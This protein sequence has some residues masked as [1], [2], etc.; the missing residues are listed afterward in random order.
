[1]ADPLVNARAAA[2]VKREQG[3]RAWSVYLHGTYAPFMTRAQV[4]VA[5]AR[6]HGRERITRVLQLA[7]AV[8]AWG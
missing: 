5:E 7:P 4:A 6:G 2:L 1:L 3:W 8:D